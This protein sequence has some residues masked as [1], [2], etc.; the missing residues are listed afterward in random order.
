MM[1]QFFSPEVPA[2]EKFIQK[3]DETFRLHRQALLAP[4]DPLKDED[5]LALAL[6]HG[7]W[8]RERFERV[9]FF[10]MGGSVLP[11]VALFGSNADESGIRFV[12]TYSGSAFREVIESVNGNAHYVFVSKSGATLET[13][14]ECAVITRRLEEKGL[15]SAHHV[16]VVT[17]KSNSMLMKLAPPECY[18]LPLPDHISGR[19]SAFTHVAALPAAVKG[20]EFFNEI[21]TGGRA[22]LEGV[23][24]GALVETGAEFL[25]H[26]WTWYRDGARVMG[27]WTY[28]EPLRP[29]ARWLR[30]VWCESLGK[31]GA[32]FD[33][34]VLLVWGPE[35]QHSVLQQFMEGEDR[36]FYLFISAESD[37]PGDSDEVVFL[38]ETVSKVMELR[39]GLNLKDVET[40]QREATASA[41]VESGHR[42]AFINIGNGGNGVLGRAYF[43]AYMMFL[44]P[45]AG[46]IQGVDPFNQPGV[47]LGKVRTREKLKA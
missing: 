44:V 19:Y 33:P 29:L 1:K 13:C 31:K 5:Y 28:D 45:L 17:A 40:A 25:R 18:V 2:D 24:E 21:L 6:K 37:G 46:F 43:M 35:D 38:P 42:V 8:L 15:N 32:A 4:F 20:E 12:E 41:L 39:Q 16:T 14:I 10:G 7:K 22:V 34:D 23:A 3:T 47:E 27:V 30:Q 9:Y 26:A 11:A 36:R